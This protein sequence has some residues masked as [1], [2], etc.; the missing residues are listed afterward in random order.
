MYHY[1]YKRATPG[2]VALFSGRMLQFLASG[3][4]GLFLPIFLY[5][6]SGN[7][8]F[9]VIWWYLIGHLAYSIILPWGARLVS[10]IGLRRCLRFSVVFDALA[11]AAIYLISY[12]FWP[13]FW[14][15]I[16]MVVLARL[17]FWLPYHVDF[18]LFTDKYDRGK[19]VSVIWATK[20]VLGILM[21]MAGG[22][23]IGWFDFKIVFVLAIIL[24]LTPAIPFMALPRTKERYVW[25]Y[26]ETIKHF[27]SQK[28][29]NLVIANMANG[30]EN[31]VA[32]IIWP[33]FIWQLLAGNFLAVGILSS[34][35]VLL[36]VVMQ[37]LMGQY[38]DL[39]N[40][41]KLL[42][43]GAGFYALGWFLKIFVLTGFHVFAA[44]TYHQLTQIFKDTPFDALNY[45]ML[46]DQG[47]YV[48]EYTVIKE[49]AVQMGKVIIL[50]FA[51]LFLLNFGLNWTFALA[52]LA[53]LFISL[54]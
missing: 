31:A 43:W 48:D 14:L 40:K 50:V 52:A 32:L 18:A 36:G 29:R 21:P 33:V 47:H 8:I 42:K 5:Q 54:L 20:A 15:S 44:G 45:E 3:L 27:F 25:G 26:W 46:A 39:F 11:Y 22:L 2:F 53:S 17:T 35:I 34:A 51:M 9:L 37:L 19:E 16:L 1:F 30:A 38:T 49:I 7:D 24:Y 23:L 28:S 10:A 41:R 12:S 6:T 13:F 4:I